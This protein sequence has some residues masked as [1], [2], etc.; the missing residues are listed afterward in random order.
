MPDG[1]PP[2][3]PFRVP[4][5]RRPAPT[6]GGTPVPPAHDGTGKCVP[7]PHARSPAPCPNL[8][9]HVHPCRQRPTSLPDRPHRP[10]RD[11]DRRRQ[12]HRRRVRRTPGR[13]RRPRDRGRPRRGRPRRAGRRHRA[14]SHCPCDLADLD[15]RR[16]PA[17]RGRHPGQQRRHPARRPDP[18]LPAGAVRPHPAADARS[19]RSGWC[20]ACLPHMYDAGWGRVV[21][22]SSVHGLRA[23]AVQVGL[24]HGQARPRGTEQGDRARGRRRTASPA[25]ASTRPTSGRR[26]WRSRSPTRPRATASPRPRC[27]R[28][29][30]SSRSRSSG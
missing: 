1:R 27:S 3:R 23:S 10:H 14:S 6:P 30:C 4:R 20:G 29:C 12:R 17:G 26:W 13:R 28:R 8:V 21:N 22:V 7:R 11:G 24:R 2:G 15:G 5:R 19:R 25:T 18:G 9:A 16:R